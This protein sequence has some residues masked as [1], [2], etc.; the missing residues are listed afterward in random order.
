MSKNFYAERIFRH[1][2]VTGSF[3]LYKVH[4][5]SGKEV[6]FFFEAGAKQG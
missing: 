1:Q 2:N 5:P 4:F 3:F 6:E